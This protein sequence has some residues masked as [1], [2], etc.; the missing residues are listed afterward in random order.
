MKISNKKILIV[1]L[2]ILLCII[3]LSIIIIFI[4]NE[5]LEKILTFIV[6]VLTIISTSSITLS[7]KVNFNDKE[8]KIKNNKNDNP[9]QLIQSG[10]SSTINYNVSNNNDITK[11]LTT[12]NDSILSIKNTNTISVIEKVKEELLKE[13][14]G[15]YNELN[16]DFLLRYIDDSSYINDKEIQEIWAKLLIKEIKCPNSVSKRTLTVIKNLNSIEA[17][18]FEKIAAKSL[19]T[20]LIHKHL[21]DDFI[22]FD[23]SNLKDAGLL[24]HENFLSQSFTLKPTEELKF[25]EGAYFLFVKNKTE[26]DVKVTFELESLTKEGV[27]LR[28]ALHIEISLDSLK[29]MGINMREKYTTLTIS[30]HKINYHKGEI[31]NYNIEDLL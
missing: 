14:I 8:I 10:D 24:K 1:G 15:V 20:G 28:N 19:S 7:I 18:N 29:K 16:K 31:I 26:K 23:V 4:D 12:I 17:T 6:T 2:L 13:D 3:I 11:V 22:Y 27:E 5:T 30:L 9:I 25:I 21:T